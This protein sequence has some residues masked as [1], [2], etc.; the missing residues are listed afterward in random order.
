MTGAGGVTAGR[1]RRH[2]RWGDRRLCMVQAR[3]SAGRIKAQGTKALLV[4]KHPRISTTDEMLA[5]LLGA[6]TTAASSSLPLTPAPATGTPLQL[7]SCNASSPFQSWL[8]QPL[9]FPH[10][11]VR[12]GGATA[13]L[14]Y[15]GLNL[16]TLG[17]SNS[18][19]GILNV[20]VDSPTNP[21]GQFW[22]FNA[23]TGQLTNHLNG[24][25]AGTT[26]SSGPLPA[27]TAVVQVPCYGQAAAWAYSPASGLLRW[28]LDASLCLDAGTAFSCADAGAQLPYC[29]SALPP[30]AR[31]SDL[32]S[33][34]QPTEK[35]AFLSASNNGFPR[36]G[37]P[38]LR[39]GE[40]L[41]GVL[42]GCGARA[43]VTPSGF[44]S[45][46]CPTSFPT[47]L[48]L[49]A[50]YNRTLWR[51]VGAVIG[52]EARALFNQGG[53]AQLM[54]FT[55]NAN[56]VRDPRWGRAMEVP[57]ESP[58]A[59]GEYAAGYIAG[60]QGTDAAEGAGFL[61]AVSMIKHFAVY[62]QEG[63]FGPSDRTHFCA[64]VSLPALVEYHW[65]PF[66]A[67]VQ[68]GRAGGIMCSAN[69][70]GVDGAAGLPSCA[71]ADF[72]L[73]VLRGQ[74]GFQGAQVTDGNG[75]GYLY[76]SYGPGGGAVNCGSDGAAGPTGA[77]RVGLRGGVDVE[78]GETL[79]TFALAAIEDGNITQEDVDRALSHTLPFLFSLGLM[80]PPATVPWAAL[81]PEHVDTEGARALA[82]EAAQQAVV[83]LRNDAGL[84]PLAIHSG[85]QIA[86]I[87]PSANDP[88]LMLS[89][90]HGPAPISA[91][92]TPLA[93]IT[94]AAAALG[95]RTVFAPGCDGVL[96]AGTGGFAAAAALAAAS[97]YTVFIGGGAPWRGGA[98]AFNATEGEEYDR[99]A[100]GLPGHQEDLLLALLGTGKPL[101]LVLMRGGP[102]AL[103][104]ALLQDARLHAI[105]DVC[106]PGELGGDAIAAVLLGTVAPS[107]RLTT[108]IYDASFVN[109]RA[110]TDYNMS[111]A[112]GIT[113]MY[114]T[115]TPQFEFGMGLSTTAWNLSWWE[116][117]SGGVGTLRA[118]QGASTPYAVNATNV[119]TRTSDLSLLAFLFPRNSTLLGAGA[120]GAAAAAAAAAAA[121]LPPLKK[122]F[123]FDRA[124]GVAPGQTVTLYFSTPQ[125]V[126]ARVLGSGAQVLL[127]SVVEVAIGAPGEVML[128]GTLRIDT[129]G[130]GVHV[131]S[132]PPW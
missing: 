52:T 76:Q 34:L 31:A 10:Y 82:L 15:T 53:I 25:C 29:N 86:V 132:P 65:P 92:H 3:F 36:L 22:G 45:T 37:V 109:E 89:N 120:G 118:G 40:A 80:D 17:F 91:Q 99:A 97:D 60:L 69:G 57:S 122:L 72:N 124:A 30:A 85:V 87:G 108:T 2:R 24:L 6:L 33:R 5:L 58:Y 32:L 13:A 93:A 115:G 43:P 9:P 20:W 112:Q 61:R 1:G 113:H 16:N 84:L 48:A 127:D 56:P 18:T 101:V 50:S 28:G 98:G 128:Q 27:G 44:A 103:S 19:G 11:N 47:G 7:W 131:V 121:P 90:Y 106:Y 38:P 66:Q 42:S 21:Y 126:A 114:Y 79:N 64:P 23:S 12:L 35:A 88:D 68:K 55:P 81:G 62:D 26:N 74:W 46:G 59:A 125:E 129:G 107:G 119:G 102:I 63:N 111:S 105:L 73:Q 130:A 83:L 67:A 75:V 95:A 104:Q 123:D 71:H 77:V 4:A 14:P 96:C 100:L 70:Y 78:L 51:A 39:Y 110:I 54:L 94:A 41:H 8:P 117:A 116:G 49:G